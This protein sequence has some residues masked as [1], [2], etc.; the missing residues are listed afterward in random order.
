MISQWQRRRTRRRIA[1]I[2]IALLIGACIVSMAI[3]A[4]P[5][6]ASRPSRALSWLDSPESAAPTPQPRTASLVVDA[7]P[8]ARMPSPPARTPSPPDIVNAR[9]VDPAPLGLGD[10]RI[11]SPTLAPPS[12]SPSPN[13]SAGPAR[14]DHRAEEWRTLSDATL[15]QQTLA[16]LACAAGGE[17]QP[18]PTLTQVAYDLWRWYVRTGTLPDGS[19]LPTLQQ[20]RAALTTL[21]PSDMVAGGSNAPCMV[22]GI[23]TSALG[24]AGIRRVGVAMVEWQAATWLIVVGE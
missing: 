11:A 19:D 2:G 16:A 6:A 21:L 3:I 22:R 17:I 1:G 4:L 20:R 7:T 15:T 24:L 13:A 14:I 10:A 8:P 18:N 23:D 9:P 12:G 5:P